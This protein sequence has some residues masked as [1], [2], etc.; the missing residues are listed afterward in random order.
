M[1]L[2]P[3]TLCGFHDADRDLILLRRAFILHEDL[4]KIVSQPT[5]APGVLLFWHIVALLDSLKSTVRIVLNLVRFR[6]V[7]NLLCRH[8]AP[9]GGV[10]QPGY[11]YSVSYLLLHATNEQLRDSSS[12]TNSM[13]FGAP[14]ATFIII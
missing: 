11:N 6:I 4:A 8:Q 3:T 2:L 9:T 12:K 14:L 5:L 13:A 7:L 1:R 10:A